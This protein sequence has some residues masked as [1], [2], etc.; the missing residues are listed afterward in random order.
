MIRPLTL[1]LGLLQ[2]P[3]PPAARLDVPFAVG[4]T[5]TYSAKLGM[6]TL[7]AGTLEVAGMDTVRGHETFPPSKGAARGVM[8]L[9]AVLVAFTMASAVLTG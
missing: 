9:A 4:E 7:G 1:L 5:L 3:E 8:A 6:L 2:A